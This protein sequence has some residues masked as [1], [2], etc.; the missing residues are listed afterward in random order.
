MPFVTHY[1]SRGCEGLLCLSQSLGHSLRQNPL[2]HRSRC[3]HTPRKSQ[4]NDSIRSPWLRKLIC[5]I[6]RRLSSSTARRCR[7]N[8][9]G[10]CSAS[11]TVGCCWTGKER[12]QCIRRDDTPHVEQVRRLLDLCGVGLNGS[13]LLV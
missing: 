13:W 5:C 12:R 8:C 10:G 2:C 9:I 1:F 3:G 7:R 6:F 4:P 11:S